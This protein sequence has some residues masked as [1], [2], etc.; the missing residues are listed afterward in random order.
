[1]FRLKEVLTVLLFLLLIP[2]AFAQSSTG[3]VGLKVI[4]AGLIDTEINEQNVEI[5]ESDDVPEEV[6]IKKESKGLAAFTGNAINNESMGTCL[7]VLL[8]VLIII[9]VIVVI[10]Y[11]FCKKKQGY[12]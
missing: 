5:L 2:M 11:F 1:M 6:N 9:I 3:S 7:K 4:T 10:G 12:P 8:P